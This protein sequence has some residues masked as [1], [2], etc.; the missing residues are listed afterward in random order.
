MPLLSDLITLK[1]IL[2]ID[3]RNTQEDTKLLFLLEYASDWIEE[4]LDRKGRLFLKTR[5][6]YYNGTGTPNL[7]LRS[8]PV[9][10]DGLAVYVDT[11]GGNYGEGSNSFPATSLLTYGSD[12][13]LRIDEENGTSR[14]GILQK[15][16]SYWP[17]P[18][19]RAPG[20]LSPFLTTDSGSVKVVYQGGYT[21]DGLPSTLRMACNTLAAKLRYFFP[22]AMDLSSE[23]YEDRS[24][25][26]GN[27]E[28]DYLMST[29]KDMIFP[30]RSWSW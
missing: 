28:K 2:E 20:V 17:K 12:Y 26:I 9:Y 16:R 13:V 7:L 29:V 1:T 24:I 4:Y 19:A 3:P 30:Y 6:E 27:K 5:T 11:Q 18:F 21:I 8:R 22:V 23:S 15:I 10:T 25:S 14:C